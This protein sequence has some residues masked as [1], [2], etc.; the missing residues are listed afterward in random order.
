M[1]L[2]FFLSSIDG[3]LSPLLIRYLGYD[4]PGLGIV[5]TI[6]IVFVAGIL[7]R[8]VLGRGVVSLWERFLSSLPLVRTI[9]SAAKQLLISVAEPK[10]SM[11]QRVVVIPYPR[12]G[13]YCFAFA[14]NEVALDSFGVI[15]DYV[16]VFI[17]STPTPF[18]GFLVM[19]K[20]D[21][22]YPT[23]ISVEEAVKFI[24]SG[25]IVVPE[26]M[27]PPQIGQNGAV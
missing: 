6:I 7:T 11:F 9:Y 24:V 13:M 23:N 4:V 20:K 19:V 12:L 18:T 26:V 8:G 21:E 16:A 17:P 3:I 10:A 5:I 14:A 22:V 25:G 15:G 2:R 27:L 1:V